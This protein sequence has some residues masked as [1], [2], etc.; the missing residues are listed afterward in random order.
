M[1]ARRRVGI[2]TSGTSRPSERERQG[3]RQGA[4][5]DLD[6]AGDEGLSEHASDPVALWRVQLA[7][8]E[9]SV[10]QR[11]FERD[12]ELEADVGLVL[13]GLADLGVQGVFVRE[14]VSRIRA[15]GPFDPPACCVL[16][17]AA[18]ALE[19]VTWPR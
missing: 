18:V 11:A 14:F 2:G 17:A 19:A 5:G 10:L 8:P 9:R 7:W 16:P 1:T 12:P 13:A 15:A 3:G 4:H 6:I